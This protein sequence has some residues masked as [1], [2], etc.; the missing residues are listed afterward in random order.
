MRLGRRPPNLASVIENSL[1][2]RNNYFD[3]NDVSREVNCGMDLQG[4]GLA[5]AT[6]L[7]TVT[8]DVGGMRIAA[9]NSSCEDSGSWGCCSD[10][11]A[12]GDP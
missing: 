7:R 12:S 11:L 5:V 2:P 3:Y 4:P 9:P 8:A 10:Q 1:V 6:S